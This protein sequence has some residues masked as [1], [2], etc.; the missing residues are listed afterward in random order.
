MDDLAI[1]DIEK[2]LQTCT[3]RPQLERHRD[4]DRQRGSGRKEK[5]LETKRWRN[6]KKELG[7]RLPTVAL[8]SQLS[9]SLVRDGEMAEHGTV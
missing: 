6:G 5:G 9:A 4:I 1:D 3:R 7:S 2:V 8:L